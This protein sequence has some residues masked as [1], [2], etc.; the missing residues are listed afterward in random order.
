MDKDEIR[1]IK[2]RKK[3]ELQEDSEMQ[4]R[5]QEMEKKIEQKK[6]EALRKI[7]TKEARERLNTVKLTNKEVVDQLETYLVQL[8]QSGQ[9]REKIDEEKLK[10]ILRSIKDEQKKD[11]N[12][13]RR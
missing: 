5:N 12:I 4:K 13:K 8:S 11:W 9:L 6:K 1:R 7:L 2:E 10:K 3:R